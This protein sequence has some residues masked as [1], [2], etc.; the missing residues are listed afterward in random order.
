MR[1][2][3]IGRVATLAGALA[4]ISAGCGGGGTDAPL[5]S[6]RARLSAPGSSDDVEWLTYDELL[7]SA[8]DG[9]GL[10]VVPPDQ[11]E[12]L[13][14][15][16]QTRAAEARA[17]VDGMIAANPRLAYLRPREP[18]RS[19]PVTRLLNGDYELTLLLDGER[20][21]FMLQGMDWLYE[22]AAH[23]LRQS[24]SRP[25]VEAGYAALYPGLANKHRYGLPALEELAKLRDA[26]LADAYRELVLRLDDGAPDAEPAGA[27]GDEDS[28]SAW[29]YEQT[30]GC[31][32][33]PH[34]IYET[35]SWQL[36]GFTTPIRYQA[37]R[38]TCVAFAVVAAVE[39]RVFHKYGVGTDYSEQELY[40]VAKRS[41][42][43]SAHDY[44]EGT[45]DTGVIDKA[46]TTLYAIDAERNWPY[47][48]SYYRIDH[49][50]EEYFEKSCVGY[51]NPYCSDRNHQT[52]RVC[53]DHDGEMLCRWR[54]PAGVT[55]EGH[56]GVA[57][58]NRVSLWN[59]FEPEN[60]L[61]SIRAH[62]VQG[63]PV[64]LDL[65]LD[66]AFYDAS[67]SPLD[68]LRGVVSSAPYGDEVGGGHAVEVTGYLA[69]SQISNP[70][71]LKPG[72]GGGYLIVKNSWGCAVGDGGYMYL[73]YQWVI[74]Q[75]KDATAIVDVNTSARSPSAT[76]TIDKSQVT[77]VG[78]QIHGNIA[79]NAS[80]TRLRLVHVY[81]GGKEIVG[82]KAFDG[83][84]DHH[85]TFTYT[86]PYTA[87]NGLHWFYAIVSD[88]FGN[89]EV[90][91]NA[92][93][94][95]YLTLITPPPG[96]PDSMQSSSVA[97]FDDP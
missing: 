51:D 46:M 33:Q 93:M 53:A 18:G 73:A 95:V 61:A 29:I 64:V 84:Q 65:H 62:L 19:A 74:D 70:A 23:G 17:Y 47:N 28:G 82:S 77:E 49:E 27:S 8:P 48:P 14:V 89:D 39:G 40:A 44:H 3:K 25:N 4:A 32:H 9:E 13:A 55:T 91:P 26:E 86:V 45:T 1:H 92:L 7:A 57:L 31:A 15:E 10:E 67:S 88:Q 80:V 83:A 5:S 41:W 35:Y 56:H 42:F 12:R 22:A 76:V 30:T 50:D 75:A 24:T 72:E 66:Q 81:P 11:D 78:E 63:H 6:T 34:N 71:Y 87:P 90:S 69:N 2:E 59:G 85:V 52:K 60:S 68:E 97:F 94:N 58:T 37:S 79:V 43:P 16:A 54:L 21:T 20:Q 96:F 38:N 36:K